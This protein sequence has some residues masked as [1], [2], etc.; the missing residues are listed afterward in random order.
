M[1][2]SEGDYKFSEFCK[3]RGYPDSYA[4]LMQRE[5]T[6]NPEILDPEWE[7]ILE[8][9]EAEVQEGQQDKVLERG[10]NEDV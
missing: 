3:K 8:E 5:Q 6:M 4:E 1:F 9:F 2:N 7:H 10:I